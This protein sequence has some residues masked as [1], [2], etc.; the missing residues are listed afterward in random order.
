M[1]TANLQ[2]EGVLLALAALCD[3]LKRQGVLNMPDLESAL[4]RAEAGA[5]D[6][7]GDLSE[8]NREAIRF[9]IRFLRMALQ[10]GERPLDYRSIAVEIGRMRSGVGNQPDRVI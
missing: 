9:P 1:N 4:D 6:R 2:M 8:A 3:T 10:T 7:G 5:S